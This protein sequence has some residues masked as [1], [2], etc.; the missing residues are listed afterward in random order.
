MRNDILERRAEIEL[1]ISQSIPKAKMCFELK[2]RPST[3]DSYLKKLGLTYAGNM[4][5]KGYKV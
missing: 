3:L 1:W 2:C 5:G 4:G